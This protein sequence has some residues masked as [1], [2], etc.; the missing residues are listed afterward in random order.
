MSKE[1][2]TMATIE[3]SGPFPTE[4]TPFPTERTHEE[5]RSA[6][7]VVGGSLIEAITAAAAVV[8]AII[9]LSHVYPSYLLPITIIATGAAVLFEGGAIAARFSQLLGETTHSKTAAAELGGG[10]GVEVLGGLATIVLGILA[11]LGVDMM[12]LASVA[13][14]VFGG[15]LLFSSATT[16]RLNALMIDGR[17]WPDMT[18]RVAREAVYA[19]S[20]V[21]VLVGLAAVILGIIAL[22]GWFPLELN[23]VAML[24]VGASILLSG[25]ALSSRMMSILHH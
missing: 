14:L 24:C 20:G 9:G 13:S 21:Q 2:T 16:A 22:A 7:V 25:A 10:M 1:K 19:A 23:L 6:E 15:T 8:L 12:I 17:G 18:R 5:E 3:T 4:K 11:L